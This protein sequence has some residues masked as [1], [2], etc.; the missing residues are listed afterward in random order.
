MIRARAVDDG[1]MGQAGDKFMSKTLCTLCLSA[2]V[3]LGMYMVL[4]DISCVL[5]MH[6]RRIMRPRALDAMKTYNALC[7]PRNIA[8]RV[9]VIASVSHSGTML[10]EGHIIPVIF[11]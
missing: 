6:G 10:N 9:A 1:I 3:G 7:R 4:K 11:P 5:G 8:V 2:F